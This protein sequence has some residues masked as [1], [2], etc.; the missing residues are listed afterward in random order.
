MY[1]IS[2]S[3][4]EYYLNFYMVYKADDVPSDIGLSKIEIA[5]ETNCKQ[6]KLYVGYIRKR[7]ICR[8][9]INIEWYVWKINQNKV[10]THTSSYFLFFRPFSL[11]CFNVVINREYR[12]LKDKNGDKEDND[13]YVVFKKDYW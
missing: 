6:G 11:I 5:T 7:N 3:K 13:N 1:H 12:Y 4:N 8:A 9:G 2:T 10:V